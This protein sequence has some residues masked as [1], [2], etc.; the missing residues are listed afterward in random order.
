MA[1]RRTVGWAVALVLAA[2]PA[3]AQTGEDWPAWGHD[4]GGQRFSPLA[5]IDRGNVGSLK[6]AWTFRTGDAYQPKGSK[7]TAFEATPIYVD[8]TLYL[9]TPLGRVIALDPVTGTQRWAYDVK[10]DK[11]A[12]YGD[13]ASRG[14]STWKSPSGQRRIFLA[15]IDAR[16]IA[17]DAATGKPCRRISAR[18]ASSTSAAA[19]ASR[20][21]AAMPT[22]RRPRRRR[23]SATPSWSAPASPTTA[24]SARPAARCAASTPSPAS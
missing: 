10:I 19:C 21:P 4:P 2:L 12:G 11:D 14:V 8:G 24:R 7:P 3:Y 1:S 20:P 16:L 18:T 13:F 23:S 15:T 6:V 22:T 5:T 17:V 9:S